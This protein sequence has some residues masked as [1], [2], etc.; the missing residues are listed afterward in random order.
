MLEENTNMVIL[1]RVTRAEHQLAALP[2]SLQTH[3]TG[4]A[5]THRGGGRKKMLDRLLSGFIVLEGVDFYS[6]ITN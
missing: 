4:T 2:L 6:W 5:P 1:Q 3:T